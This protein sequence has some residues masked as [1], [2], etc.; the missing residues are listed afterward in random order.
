MRKRKPSHQDVVSE[1][2][3]RGRRPHAKGGDD[4]RGEGESG[5]AAK[6]TD[7]VPE[8]LTK[9]VEVFFHHQLHRLFNPDG[10]GRIRS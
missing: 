4:D 6:R 5:R 7:G 3:R 8:V 2:E 9:D 10:I 1:R